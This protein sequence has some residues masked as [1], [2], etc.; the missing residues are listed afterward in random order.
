MTGSNAFRVEVQHVVFIV[1][2]RLVGMAIYDR[3][4]TS[5]AGVEIDLGDVM[6]YVQLVPGYIYDGVAGEGSGPCSGIDITLDDTW[7]M[8]CHSTRRG[9]PSCPGRRRG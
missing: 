6:Q 8:R 5:G 7:S 9:S 2:F 1:D 3:G 4:E